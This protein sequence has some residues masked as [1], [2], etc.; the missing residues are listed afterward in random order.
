[1]PDPLIGAALAV[2]GGIV[3]GLYMCQRRLLYRPRKTR[4]L[5]DD[6]VMLGVN[7][8]ELVTA[9]GLTLF[10]WYL[11]PRPGRPVILYFHGNGG[12][13]GY[14]AE[15][16]RRFAQEGYGVLLAEYRGY[17]GNP[18]FP[19][20]RGLFID[21]ETALDFLAAVGL[22]PRRIVLWG[23]SLGSGIAV[24]LAA[25]HEIGALVLEAPFTSV[26]ACAQRRYPFV[27]AA[28]LLHD[29]FDS[30]SRIGQVSAPLLILHGERDMVVPVRHG[31]AL[32]AA[33]KA[34]KEGWFSPDARHETLAQF[35]ALDVAVSFI[36]RRVGN[37]VA[38][39][40]TAS[41]DSD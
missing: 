36:E 15:R 35:G 19:S 7:E 14:R 24:Y 9:D 26:A 3:G 22:A 23:E 4:P 16:L 12:H 13:I 27:P 28:I 2:Y 29:R 34:L 6:L 1:M 37:C 40:V 17:G 32:L 5:L 31:R 18:G 38:E 33:A 8:V 21:G 20:E 11:P 10:S 30:L 39:P 25:G 41:A